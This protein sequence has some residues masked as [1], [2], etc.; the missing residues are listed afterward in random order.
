MLVLEKE[1]NLSLEESLAKEK[2]KVEKLT[3]DL[4]LA[5]DSNVRMSRIIP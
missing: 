3:T 4:S 1:R 2:D 5:N